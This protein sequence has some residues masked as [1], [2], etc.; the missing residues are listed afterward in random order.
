MPAQSHSIIPLSLCYSTEYQEVYEP[1]YDPI[2]FYVDD[3]YDDDGGDMSEFFI[4]LPTAP[5]DA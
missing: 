3:E 2:I 4:D 1:S 5:C